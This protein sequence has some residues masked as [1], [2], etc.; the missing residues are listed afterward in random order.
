[1]TS[2]AIYSSA[3]IDSR[4]VVDGSSKRI[5]K[6]VNSFLEKIAERQTNKKISNKQI[7]DDVIE[8]SLASG[9]SSISYQELIEELRQKIR[10]S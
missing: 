2:K 7:L 4:D 3:I 8:K 9:I 1:M 5:S 10:T 6:I